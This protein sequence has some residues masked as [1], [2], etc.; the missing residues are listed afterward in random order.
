MGEEIGFENDRIFEFKG[1]VTLTL[2]L[3]WVILHTVMNHSSTST[4]ILNSIEIEEIFLWTDRR[5]DGRTYILHA[6]Y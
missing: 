4:Y 6:R 3:D 1:P 2:T 5:T